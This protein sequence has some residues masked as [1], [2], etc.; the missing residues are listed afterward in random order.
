MRDM[1]KHP[2]VKTLLSWVAE[3]Q[4]AF[5]DWRADS[6]SDVKL[7][8]G[9]RGQWTDED[10]QA[11]EDMGIDPIT[12]NRTFP[13]INLLLGSQ[14][15]NK[16]NIVAKGRTKK[17][18]DVSQMM[19][20]GIKFVLDQSN[21][22]FLI[23]QAFKDSVIP[24]FGCISPSLNPDPRKE[25]LSLIQ[26][27]WKEQWWDPLGSP[28]LEPEKCRYTFNQRWTDLCD[29]Q[30]LFPDK[31]Q[32][33]DNKFAELSSSQ[34]NEWGT[35]YLDEA[36]VVEEYK[37]MMAGIQWTDSERRRV[38]P[39]E[40]WYTLFRS[41][42]FAVFADGRVIELRDD[43]PI[44]QQYEIVNAAQQVVSA[45]VRKVFSTT[46]V[47][48]LLLQQAPTPFPHDEF[49]FIPFIGYLDRYN[50]PYG[51]PR[52]IRGQDVEVNKRRSMALA[53]LKARRVIVERDVIDGGDT[54]LQSLYEEANKPDGFLVVNPGKMNS[55]AIQDQSELSQYQIQLLEQSE[56]EIEETTGASAERQGHGI[57][58]Q[59][60]VAIQEKKQGAQTMSAPL[61]ENLRR[62]AKMLGNQI[63]ANIQGFWTGE[64]VLRITDSMT[65]G[66]KFVA[67]NQ[68]AVSET[69]IIEVRNNITQ[70]KFDLVVSDA[71]QSDT[72]R[73]QNMNM[74]I[75][76]VKKSPPEVIPH[77]IEMAFELSNIPNKDQLLARL[78][79]VLGLPTDEE[80]MSAEEIRQR[81]A[82]ELEQQQAKQ[83]QEE[84][85]LDDKQNL[86]LEN[87]QL[88]NRKVA[89][90]IYKL[91]SDAGV[92]QAKPVLQK[93]KDDKKHEIA[94]EQIGLEQFKAGMEMVDKLLQG[95]QGST[96][97]G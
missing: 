8:D 12:I 17:D 71:P 2:D 66:E 68:I 46:F 25:R 90:E 45:N 49:P 15:L 43:L 70:G 63:M 40:M 30:A 88:E 41:L 23:S 61:L 77:L 62:S 92:A 55:I 5:Q 59:S 82:A 83:Q 27:D 39:V 95:S 96:T 72:I 56:R 44:M 11:A 22:E 69:G 33:L 52:Q 57:K 74:I 85:F 97:G 35:F 47:G 80:D 18:S 73:E 67:L 10:W 58:S 86:E 34:K 21:G 93:D 28:W 78:R 6:W 91:I 20:E 3:S 24:G 14:V 81:V 31:R 4:F 13:A 94:Q 50:Y 9:G 75:E 1:T 19:S 32:E 84:Q 48:D 76:W 7:Y 64:K 36:T 87:D 38:R 26:R 37:Q 51:V 42:W 89:A 16:F 60:G 29:L 79:P 53:L 54:G 65:G